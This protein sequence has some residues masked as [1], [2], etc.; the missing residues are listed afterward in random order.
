MWILLGAIEYTRGGHRDLRH[1]RP[2]HACRTFQKPL[3]LPH[4][5]WCK[6]DTYCL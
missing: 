4:R 3:L 6:T 2:G 1:F 5:Y